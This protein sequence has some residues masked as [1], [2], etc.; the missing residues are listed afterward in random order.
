MTYLPNIDY[1][2]E[3]ARG[4]V[5]GIRLKSKFGT[6]PDLDTTQEDVWETGGNIH[7]PTAAQTFTIVS[8]DA[9][10]AAAGTGAR[11]VYVQGL[12]ANYDFQ[13]EFVTLNGTS[14]VT[15]VNSYLRMH[16]AYVVEVGSSGQEEGDITATW[17]T[18]ANNAWQ[19]TQGFGQTRLCAFT[20]PD[21]MEV[22]LIRWRSAI[23]DPAGGNADRSTQFDLNVRLYN[24]SSTD[25]YEGW[26][27]R[28]ESLLTQRGASNAVIE[29]TAPI[30]LPARADI[31]VSALSADTNTEIETHLDYYEYDV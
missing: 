17:T 25:N 13:S 5:N 10:D 24:A 9:N 2:L 27:R 21:S 4:N 31:R 6:N 23:R 20:V 1:H 8:S 18:D 15:T 19:I 16:R 26:R 3:I 30:I 22:A 11:T 12:D 29:F 14:N 7:Y 28:R